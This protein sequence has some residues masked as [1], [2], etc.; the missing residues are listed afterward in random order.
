ML[1]EKTDTSTGHSTRQVALMYQKLKLPIIPLCPPDHNGMP[2]SHRERCKSP[3][4]APLLSNWSQRTT[5]EVAEI[6]KWLDTWPQCNL[7]MI[8]GDTGAFNLVG[9]DIDGEEGE[10]LLENYAKGDLPPTWEFSTGKGRRII[11]A[12]PE[13]FK[14][15]K[16]AVQTKDGELAFLAQ[17][18]QTVVPPSTH[19]NGTTYSWEKELKVSDLADCPNWLQKIIA[20]DAEPIKTQV[21]KDQ[22]EDLFQEKPVTESDFEK[23][24]PE[25]G[26]NNHLTRLAGS[27]ISRQNIP[28]KEVISFLKTW[29]KEHCKPPLPEQEIHIMVETIYASEQLKAAKVSTAKKG[30][31]LRPTEF[32][33]KFKRIQE[34]KNMLWRY[35][36]E[37][38]YFYSCD[39]TRGPWKTN[40][41]VYLQKE[42]RNELIK[43]SPTLDKQ[44]YVQEA[45]SA[46]KELLADPV[47]DDIF[48]IGLHSDV[49]NVYVKNGLLKWDTLELKPWDSNTFSTLQIPVTWTTGPQIKEP[50]DLWT[51]CLEEWIPDKETRMFLQEYIGYCLVPDCGFRTAVFLFGGGNNGKSLFL[52][53]IANLFKG[54]I[55]FTPLHWL[56]GRFESAKLMDKLI[57]VCA[58]IDSKYME[59]TNT[60]KA[61]ISGD[62]I[63]AEIKHGKT[64][65]FHPVCRLMFSAN[66]IPRS[67]DQS[68]GWYSRWQFIDFPRKFK[69]NA[70]FKRKLLNE[71]RTDDALSALLLWAVEGLQRLYANGEFTISESMSKAAEQYRMD[72]DSVQAFINETIAKVGHVGS[73]TTL[74]I[75]SLYAVYK[76]WCE[77]NGLR[78]VSQHEFIRRV[79]TLDIPKDSRKL[80]NVSVACFLG[81][82]F[83][84]HARDAG[85][86]DDYLMNE[87]IRLSGIK[88]TKKQNAYENNPFEQDKDQRSDIYG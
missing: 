74:A 15:K 34:Q 38:G 64:F 39:A 45:I 19:A 75:N 16:K 81:V 69:T 62:P 35:C 5:T 11:Y 18:Q 3:G 14:S 41:I 68:D 73:N 24:V 25:S 9:I 29:N 60:I 88:S 51:N 55:S 86:E 7:G 26:R 53:I 71:L 84:Q 85:Y 32:A 22:T 63:R 79:G 56:D 59:E 80:K 43:Q 67:N 10:V 2:Y 20:M 8:L 1:T 72:N 58:D 40:D 27:L 23:D 77:D 50:Y 13:N 36:V 66:N 57:N 87:A 44:Q 28:K 76:S 17:G 12:L 21:A 31:Q 82:A 54:Y 49:E 83:K 33:L 47:N 42:I 65:D 30:A 6:E 61:I 52:E 48:D 70:G 78:V 4:K 46:F 37:R